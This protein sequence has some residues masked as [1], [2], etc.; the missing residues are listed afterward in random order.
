MDAWH[1]AVLKTCA[2]ASILALATANSAAGPAAEGTKPPDGPPA[3]AL[4]LEPQK[5]VELDCNS[6]AVVVANDKANATQGAIRLSLI[7]KDPSA[8][9]PTGTWRVVSS[10]PQHTG[11]FAS[12]LAIACREACPLTVSTDDQIQL[13]AP[14]PK[15][16]DKLGST[17]A[18][19][20]AVIKTRTLEM[21]VT[22]FEGQAI[23]ALEQASCRKTI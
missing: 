17:E 10:D 23:G 14:A 12:A 5:P 18:L 8:K 6:R 11:S 20:L 2:L 4:T 22:T 7:L 9:P 21:R 16:I 1:L 3:I 13:W 19:T 15:T